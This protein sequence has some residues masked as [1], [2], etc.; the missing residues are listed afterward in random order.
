LASQRA[1]VLLG[2][3]EKVTVWALVDLV[4]ASIW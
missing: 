4:S 3:Q 1:L 2:S